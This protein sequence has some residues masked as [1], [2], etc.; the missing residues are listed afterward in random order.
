MSIVRFLLG[1]LFVSALLFT[2]VQEVCAEQKEPNTAN[3]IDKQIAERTKQ[4]QES[5]RQR[6]SQLSPSFQA[7]IESQARQ[8]VAK[9]LKKWNNGELD[10]RIALPGWAA[11][12]QAARFVARHL[13]FSGSPAGSWV[14][15]IGLDSAA[16][17]VTS[18]QQVLKTWT[19]LIADSAI[20]RDASLGSFRQNGNVLSYFIRVVGTIV[21]RR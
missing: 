18:V 1:L 10:L 4:Y 6:A 13:P 17:T 21:Q 19:V 16:L 3:N 8:T 12:Q 20:V 7:K 9:G 14:F 15:G 11:A 2:A 5:L